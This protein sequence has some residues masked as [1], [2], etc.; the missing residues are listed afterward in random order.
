M[1][2]KAKNPTGSKAGSSASG[3]GSGKPWAGDSSSW[4]FSYL[5]I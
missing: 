4:L 3:Q 2:A 1:P 5:V